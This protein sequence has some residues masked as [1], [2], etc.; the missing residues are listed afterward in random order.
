MVM[1][2]SP[3]GREGFLVGCRSVVLCKAWL[4]SAQGAKS[5]R[6]ARHAAGCPDVLLLLQQ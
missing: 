5:I 2:I 1:K 4:G 6:A 3:N